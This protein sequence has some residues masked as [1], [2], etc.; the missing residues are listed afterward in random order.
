M[1]T[2]KA[3][4]G[5]RHDDEDFHEA[6]Q[7]VGRF[8]G[9]VDQHKRLPAAWGYLTPAECETPCVQQQR[10]AVPGT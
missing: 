1:R 5:A 6:S 9:D 8:L 10:I 2:M 7:H 3:E 4:A